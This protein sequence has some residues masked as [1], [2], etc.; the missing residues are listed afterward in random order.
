MRSP[1]GTVSAAW[2]KR[3]LAIDR[4][5]HLDGGCK[6]VV[7]MLSQAA[8]NYLGDRRGNLRA[9]IFDWPGLAV[10]HARELRQLARRLEGMRTTRKFV[11]HNAEREHVGTSIGGLAVNL[12]RGHVRRRAEQDARHRA[13]GFA[14]RPV[15]AGLH[16]Q[17]DP[18]KAE[19]ED[20]QST[21]DHSHHI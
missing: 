17:V 12:L 7:G 10:E 20:L 21:V 18:R 1:P 9:S 3:R 19:I 16:R 13:D 15:A 8:V 2:T 6:A 5:E 11:H 4:G 14:W